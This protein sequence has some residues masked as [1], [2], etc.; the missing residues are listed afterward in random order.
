ME[1]EK[2]IERLRKSIFDPNEYF[3]LSLEVQ[4]FPLELIGTGHTICLGGLASGKL[5]LIDVDT[6][7]GSFYNSHCH[8]ISCLRS[9]NM[10]ENFLI[11]GDVKGNVIMWEIKTTH[12]VS[13][14]I[15]K[16]SFK[17]QKGQI[18]SIFFSS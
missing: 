1:K 6:G 17:D 2:K 18:S 11:T 12:N 14:L 8:T 13:K 9:D 10:R 5:V 15:E 16:R 7:S 3:D 4:N